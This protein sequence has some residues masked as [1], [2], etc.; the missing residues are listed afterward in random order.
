MVVTK[1]IYM[2]QLGESVTEGTI[3]SWYVKEGEYVKKYEPIAEVLSDKV[4]AEIPSLF[5][6]T[7]SR[8]VAKEGEAVPVGALI[9][10][11]EVDSETKVDVGDDAEK[12]QINEEKQ[13]IPIKTKERRYSPAVL[14][15]AQE[16]N[17]DL[18]LIQGTG[19]NGRI[20]RKDVLRYIEQQKQKQS[21]EPNVTV[22]SE[23]L[24]P[25][26]KL[27]PKPTDIEI[28][29]SGIRKA[30]AANTMRSVQEIPHGWMMVE[31]DVTDLVAYR[32]KI[33]H[34]FKQKEGFNLTYFS[35]FIKAVVEA[36][37]EYPQLNSMW[38]GDKIIQKKDINISIAV[39]AG[40]VLFTPVIK[41]ADEKSIK[42]I[43]KEVHELAIKARSGKL[44]REDVEGGTFTVNNTGVFGSV[45]SMG[46]I[47][48]PQ[49]AILQIETIVKRPVVDKNGMIGPRDIVNLCL[50]LDHRVLDGLVCGLFL[51]S[52]K[53][54]V[55]NMNEHTIKLY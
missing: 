39:A 6:G 37:K 30:I 24:A 18:N 52:V 33:K 7:I 48:Y 44:T 53:E 41:N 51:K 5:S 16:H 3:N 19:K 31:A 49:A 27:T 15:L 46:I 10:Y 2:P 43:A 22:A 26:P 47:N 32:E 9:C 1:E 38:A 4:T 50:S 8:I 28:P 14:K 17:L 23:K 21:F 34:D 20:T 12:K 29:L 42:G 11:I 13:T 55:E 35:F 40:D 36:L 25:Q 54:K 45:Q